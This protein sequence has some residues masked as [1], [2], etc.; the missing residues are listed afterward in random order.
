MARGEMVQVLVVLH[1]TR[2]VRLGVYVLH[3]LLEREVVDT[4]PFCLAVG[5]VPL[6]F[7]D[8]ALRPVGVL[9]LSALHEWVGGIPVGHAHLHTHRDG[10]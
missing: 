8:G 2:Q 5:Q 9:E 1:V 6:G 4:S 10:F 3:P 7:A